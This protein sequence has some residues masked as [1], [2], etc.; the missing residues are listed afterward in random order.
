MKV[1]WLEC[2]GKEFSASISSYSLHSL[3]I[4]TQTTLFKDL[5]I[6]SRQ[7]TAAMKSVIL[8]KTDIGPKSK[9]RLLV[10]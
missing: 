4:R 8:L 5:L 6:R 3:S 2:P 1:A 10:H 7:E 9:I